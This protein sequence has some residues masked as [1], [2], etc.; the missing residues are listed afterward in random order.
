MNVK[1]YILSQ[2]LAVALVIMLDQTFTCY[3]HFVHMTV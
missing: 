3:R 2:L 1:K